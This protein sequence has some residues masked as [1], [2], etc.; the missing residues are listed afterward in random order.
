MIALF[1]VNNIQ[2]QTRGGFESYYYTGYSANSAFVPRV[3]FQSNNNWYGE[4]RYNYESGQTLSLYAGRTFG[5]GSWS[6]TPMAGV[7]AGKLRGGSLG[8]NASLTVKHISFSSVLQYT[9][10]SRS[11]DE[12]FFYS[13]SE[14]GYQLTDHVYAGAV[15]QQTGLC[16]D[17]NSIDPG[18]QLTVSAGD[19]RFPVY[20]FGPQGAQRYWVL[21]ISREWAYGKPINHAKA[22]DTP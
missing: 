4:V 14:L 5:N 8:A 1:V 12:S 11:S 18:L 20:F 10:S 9:A 16:H 19:W 15:L 21:G 7:V 13:W 2:A 6:L 22:I 17:H 3:Y